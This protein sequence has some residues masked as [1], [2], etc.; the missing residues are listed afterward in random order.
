LKRRLSNFLPATLTLLLVIAAGPVQAGVTGKVS[1]AVEDGNTGAPVIGATVR[2]AGTSLATKTDEDGEYFIINVPVGKYDLVATHVGFETVTRK[3]VRILVDLTTP[4]DF[5]L[6]QIAVELGEAVVVYASEPIIRRDLTASRSIF[7][8]DRLKNLPNI[9]TVQTVLTNYP[10]VVV[11]R[12]EELHVRGGR[13]GQISYYFDGFSVQDPFVNKAGIRIMPTALEELSLTS[14]GFTAEYGE[15]LSGVVNAVTREG[16]HA[17]RGGLRSYE[18]FTHT[19]SVGDAD[20][21]QMDRHGNRS[22]SFDVSGPVPGLDGKRYSFFAAGEYLDKR[23][24]LPHDREASYTTA[25]KLSLQP[26]PRLKL[27]S[28]VTFFDSNGD[29][30]T[31][32]DVNGRSYDFNLDGLPSFEKRAY[33]AGVSGNYHFNERTILSAAFNRFSTRT[34]TAPGH[35]MDVHWSRWPGYS[36]DADG[37]YDGTI[38][39]DNY[40]NNPDNSDPYEIFGFTTG[41]DFEPTYSFRE[42]KYSSLSG[43]LVKQVDKNNQ[44]KAGFEYRQYDIAKDFR[45]FY[46]TKPYYETYEAN[47][48]Y[49]S[50]FLQDKIEYAAFVVNVGLRYDYRDADIEYNSTP[51]DTVAHY[52]DA[53][54]KSR[55]SPRLGVSF[56]VSTKTVMH[57]NYGVYYQMPTFRFLYFN[58]EGDIS[59]GLPLLGNPD[60]A[61]EQTASYELGLDHLIGDDIRLDATAYY[62]DIK[63]LVS[64]RSF[65]V[66]TITVTRFTNDDYGSVKGF[67]VS[68][69]KLP[70][71]A[72]WSGSVSYGYMLASGNGSNALEPY[73]NLNTSDTILPVTEYPL[74]FDQRHTVTAMADWHV[75]PQWS[76]NLF[77]LKLPGAWGFSMVGYYGSGL[78]YTKTD[79]DGNRFGERNEGRLPAYYSV[80]MRFNKDFRTG[81][82]Q[83]LTFFV[84]VDNVFNRRNVIDVFSRTGLPDNDAVSVS[85]SLATNQEEIDEA[86]RLYDHDPQHYSPPRTIRTGF[87]LSF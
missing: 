30:Y 79:A 80:D 47:P 17:Y 12:G 14:G 23:T 29:L 16:G 21:G 76:G 42:T 27:K 4:V 13:S 63:D 44:V 81:A 75:P 70:G 28:N 5:N 84:E 54:P 78:P 26:T 85:G 48:L 35:L 36:E 2:V 40:G 66:S 18:G 60:L 33:L 62:K 31:H 65:R 38:H 51:E 67:D 11:D 74:D 24:H 41:D 32:R 61:P 55:W 25:A 71:D 53:D 86:N 46:N 49:A 1:G 56:P 57:F 77:G 50:C 45:Q 68:L 9:V 10:G 3:E 82:S 73:Y 37:T 43:S 39:E 19:Y 22:L 8:A 64:A 6:D 87:E 59:S 69:E 58:P 15:A 34:L 72:H 83:I 20:W 52:K 7:T